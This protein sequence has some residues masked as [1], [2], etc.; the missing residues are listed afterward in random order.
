MYR[1]GVLQTLSV[2]AATLGSGCLKLLDSRRPS[3]LGD[4]VVRNWDGVAHEFGLTIEQDGSVVH[5]TGIELEGTRGLELEALAC[6]WSGRGPFVVT[7]TLDGGKTETVRVDDAVT[8]GAGAYANL[9]FTVSESGA[10]D[11]SGF[12]DDGGLRCRRS[13]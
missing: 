12:F 3:Y 8:Q 4:V 13:E 6:E 7:C 11:W 1:R 9:T 10:L 2:G 5:E